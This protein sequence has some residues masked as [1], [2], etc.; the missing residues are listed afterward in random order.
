MGMGFRDKTN[1][2]FIHPP[3]QTERYKGRMANIRVR[4]HRGFDTGSEYSVLSFVWRSPKRRRS[5][6]VVD[7]HSETDSIHDFFGEHPDGW[8]GQN[9]NVSIEFESLHVLCTPRAI[10]HTPCV[11]HKETFGID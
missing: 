10:E 8:N 6:P 1:V 11:I 9:H 5:A 7:S 2:G 3:H 4:R